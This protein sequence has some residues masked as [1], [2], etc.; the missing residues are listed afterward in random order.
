[1]YLDLNAHLRKVVQSFLPLLRKSGA[2]EIPVDFYQQSGLAQS[3]LMCIDVLAR[4]LGTRLDWSSVLNETLQEVVEFGSILSQMTGPESASEATTAKGKKVKKSAGSTISPVVQAEHLKLLGSAS[5]CIATLSSVLGA[6]AL[7]HL[8]VIMAQNLSS[9]EYI[10]GLVVAGPG[11]SPEEDVQALWRTRVLLV[12]SVLSAV[13]IIVAQLSNFSHPYIPR[14]LSASLVLEGMSGSA[15]EGALVRGDVDRCLSTI[16][17]KIPTRLSVPLF[18]Q[19]APTLLAAGHSAACRF[20]DLMAEVWQQLDRTT[21][22]AHMGPLSTLAT[23]LLDYRRVFGDQSAEANE[24]DAAAA[25]AVVEMCLKLTESE[26]KS[27]LT[28]LA[29][30]RDVRFKPKAPAARDAEPATAE[31]DWRK[32]SRA[33]SYFSLADVLMSK[34]KSLFHPVMALLWNSAVD[35]L[36]NFA[37]TAAAAKSADKKVANADAEENGKKSKKRKQAETECGAG[38]GELSRVVVELELVAKY[39]LSSVRECCAQDNGGFVEEVRST[40]RICYNLLLS[41]NN[42]VRHLISQTKFD[43]MMPAVVA[44]APLLRAFSSES[45]YLTYMEEYVGACLSALT[46]AVGRDLLW[47]PLNHKILL[48]TRDPRKA[49]RIA[50]VKILHRLF[51]E[52]NR[53]PY[54]SRRFFC[55]FLHTVFTFFFFLSIFKIVPKG[56]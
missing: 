49:V 15:S 37:T 29:E 47:K 32:Y 50:A 27:F 46:V 6:Q 55:K 3:A 45:A 16:A 52:V 8:P 54:I 1:M 22:V 9:L 35:I 44:L 21:V 40:F 51:S 31:G 25:D 34:L 41:I 2:E 4:F 18:L 12:R 56:G 30:W 26:L 48:L 19:S 24:V 28:R 23:L 5:L 36:T 39:V 17:T 14:I 43:K 42:F 13:S 53:S 10:G 38:E 11:E 33:V 20:A 7:P